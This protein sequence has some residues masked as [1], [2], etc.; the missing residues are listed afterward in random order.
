MRIYRNKEKE[1]I[2]DS[3]AECIDSDIDL[4][5]KRGS[6]IMGDNEFPVFNKYGIY[7]SIMKVIRKKE[8]RSS[9]TLL[10]YACVFALLLFNV[11][12]FTY[13]LFNQ[14]KLEY[15][16]LQTKKGEKLVVVLADG[17]KVWM[18]ADT[19]LIYP[20][21]FV[22]DKRCV[23]LSGEAFFQVS[24]N[25][26]SPF[27][28]NVEDMKIK[29]TGTSF[30]VSAYPQ[31][32]DIVTTLEEGSI[33]ISS[34]LDKKLVYHILPGQT[35][36]YQKK[37]AVCRVA[38]NLHYKEQSGWRNDR[39]IFRNKKL[40]LVLNQ[41]SRQF[42]VKFKIIDTTIKDF[43]YTFICKDDNLSV[44]KN[45][46]EMITPIQFVILGKGI[47]GVKKKP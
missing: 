27:F 10:K 11:A 29:V 24:K 43:T 8:S 23:E 14:I 19:K 4:L 18:N 1:Q 37:K 20:K 33:S 47:I 44:I 34:S 31:E 3:I 45:M 28:V 41:L 7:E 12:Y 5:K 16:E 9:W 22:G 2:I 46:M 26:K 36:V 21:K 25:K 15:Q 42:N 17:T 13:P 38:E 30:N 35:A 32:E 6:I 40:R 39:L